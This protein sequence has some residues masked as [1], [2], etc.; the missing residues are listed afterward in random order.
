[1][2][3]EVEKMREMM[4]GEMDAKMAEMKHEVAKMDAKMDDIKNVLTAIRPPPLPPTLAQN[5]SA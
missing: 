4:M 5:N 3:K 2:I 1:M